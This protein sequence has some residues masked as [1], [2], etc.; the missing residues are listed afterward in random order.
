[1]K[2]TYYAAM[3]TDGFIAREDGDVS[4][5]DDLDIDFSETGAEEF[6]HS[7][8]GLIMGRKTYDFVFDYG[9]WPYEDKPAWVCTSNSVRILEGAK[10]SIAASPLQIVAEAEAA[11]LKH[12]WFVGGG[13]LAS[14][15]VAEGL[16]THVSVSQMPVTLESGIPLFSDHLLSSLPAKSRETE[17]K[18]GFKQLNLRLV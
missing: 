5:L 4:F 8:D 10:L 17:Q 3:S 9:A 2:I 6:F 12:L 14:W 7:V 13:K 16:L 18:A 1:M 15:F 11:G